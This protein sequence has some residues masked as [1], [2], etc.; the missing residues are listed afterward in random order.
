MIRRFFL[1][2]PIIWLGAA[3]T[4]AANLYLLREPIF[5]FYVNARAGCW[6]WSPREVEYHDGMMICPGQSARATIII[7]FPQRDD[8][9]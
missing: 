1:W 3:A 6:P 2:A 9:I 5:V 8:R 4:I 7:T